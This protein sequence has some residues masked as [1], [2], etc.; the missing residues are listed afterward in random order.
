MRLFMSP[1]Y[2]GDWHFDQNMRS[3]GL[4]GANLPPWRSWLPDMEPI[5]AFYG[6][7]FPR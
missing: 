6:W 1:G 3:A 4:G 5:P 7:Y 2:F